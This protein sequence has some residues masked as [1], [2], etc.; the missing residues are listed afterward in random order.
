MKA[1]PKGRR[2]T[3]K[4]HNA[5][6]RI[7]S[8]VPKWAYWLL[9][10]AIAG[11]YVFFL[12]HIVLHYSMPWKARFGEVPQPEGYTVRGIDISHY[13]STIRWDRLASA[14][15]SDTPISFIFMKA[16]E[17]TNIFDKTFNHNFHQARL[18]GFV[19]GAYHFYI[20]GAS[21]EQQA[22]YYLSQVHLVPG[23]LP[24]VLDVEKSGGQSKAEIRDG[25]RQWLRIVG[26]YYGTKPIIYTYHSFKRDYLNTPE[27]DEYPFWIAHYYQSKLS[28][29]GQW[30]FWQY[31]DM[32]RVDGIRG[33]VDCNVFNGTLEALRKL[34]I[35][36]EQFPINY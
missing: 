8:N 27:F 19:R 6:V 30:Q 22:R 13:Q 11:A 25:V 31:T 7:L 20:P 32:G 26:E 18:N 3:T 24:P 36:P 23:D 17:G 10:I 9:G 5:L 14:Q 2:R 35:T 1:R 34:C 4:S 16:T 33:N 12:F 15:I 21:A 28:Y 29:R